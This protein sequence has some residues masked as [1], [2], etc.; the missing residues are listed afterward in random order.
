VSKVTIPII[1]AIRSKR[2]LAFAYHGGE[3]VVEPH[4]Y[5]LDKW[6]REILCAYQVSGVSRSGTA[7]GWRTFVVSELTGLRVDA[8]HFDQARPEYQRNDGA[9]KSILA[10]L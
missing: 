1:E 3:R 5:G 7:Q 9:F 8:R 10:Q 2:R 4:T 6:Q